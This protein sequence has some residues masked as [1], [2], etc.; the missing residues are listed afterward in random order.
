MYSYF[1]PMFFQ[2][3]CVLSWKF[4]NPC[5]DMPISFGF[6]DISLLNFV[7]WLSYV[8]LSYYRQAKYCVLNYI[9]TKACFYY[10]V[11]FRAYCVSSNLISFVR[12]GPCLHLTSSTCLRDPYNIYQKMVLWSVPSER[13]RLN[14]KTIKSRIVYRD[15]NCGT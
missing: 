15:K 6:Q 1:P 14:S 2:T 3:L 4:S 10:E 12:E 9:A 5:H 8:I 13:R 11:L 7:L